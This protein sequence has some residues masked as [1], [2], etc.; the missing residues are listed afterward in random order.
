MIR[1]HKQTK[2][3]ISSL[4]FNEEKFPA[5]YTIIDLGNGDSMRCDLAERK[6]ENAYKQKIQE[7]REYAEQLE[8]YCYEPITVRVDVNGRIFSGSMCMRDDSTNLEYLEDK[9]KEKK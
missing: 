8:Y 4:C 6:D 3:L 1:K 7:L 5:N 2:Y 9:Y